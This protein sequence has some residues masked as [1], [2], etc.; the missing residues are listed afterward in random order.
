MRI[1]DS[2]LSIVMGKIRDLYTN[3]KVNSN[4]GRLN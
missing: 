4:N 3:P 1:I 2:A